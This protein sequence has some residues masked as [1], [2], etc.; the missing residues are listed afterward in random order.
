MK[1]FLFGAGATCG[2]LGAPISAHFGREL[3]KIDHN[4]QQNYPAIVAVVKHL[5]LPPDKW[6]LEEVWSCI[7]FTAKLHQAIPGA[8]PDLDESPQL[9]KALLKV[10]GKRL[11]ELADRCLQ[12]EDY[13]LGHLLKNEVG[14]GDVLVSFNYDT[15]VE[16]LA[17]LF[18]RSLRV[19]GIASTDPSA[20]LVKPHGSTSWAMDFSERWVDWYSGS[21]VPRLNSLASEEVTVDREPLLLGTV[22]IK[23]ELILEVQDCGGFHCVFE[24]ILRQWRSVVEAVRDADSL[25]AVGYGFPK[26]DHYGRFLIQEGLRLRKAKGKDA[27]KIEFYELRRARY[28]RSREIMDLVAVVYG[29][30][31]PIPKYRDK[32]TLAPLRKTSQGDA[33]TVRL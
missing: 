14:N 31:T 33:S 18:D 21:G 8:Q 16:R 7:D 1:A 5:G 19:A 10:Y 15:V 32:V 4:W 29:S 17:R 22:P 13:T 23:S 11:D 6:G 24:T 2:T 3:N 12:T 28:K 26:E 9:K 30:A 20:T 27:P 25:I